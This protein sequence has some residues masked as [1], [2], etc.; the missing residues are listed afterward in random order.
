MK[1]AAHSTIPVHAKVGTTLTLAERH[2]NGPT[3]ATEAPGGLPAFAL[4]RTPAT[5]QVTV[6]LRA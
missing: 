3:L 2:G 1:R 5:A 6:T 4:G